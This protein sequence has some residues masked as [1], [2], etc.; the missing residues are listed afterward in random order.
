MV[1]Y[2]VT[3]NTM[4]VKWKDFDTYD[5]ECDLETLLSKPEEDEVE[6]FIVTGCTERIPFLDFSS[7]VLP[8][9]VISR[10]SSSESGSVK[11]RG[12]GRSLTNRALRLDKPCRRPGQ[13]ATLEKV[14][15]SV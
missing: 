3:N 13:R 12:R 5:L 8:K 9:K 1:F 7:N 6:S 4:A 15:H 14:G 11:L 10:N 2:Q